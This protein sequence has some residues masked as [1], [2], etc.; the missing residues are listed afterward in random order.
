MAG[1]HDFEGVVDIGIGIDD[2]DVLGP[3]HLAPRPAIVHDAADVERVGL[4]DLDA[5]GVVEGARRGEVV[6]LD[7]GDDCFEEREEDAA[8]VALPR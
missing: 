3:R 1:G 8:S 4:I 2:E 5:G 7:V 6:V